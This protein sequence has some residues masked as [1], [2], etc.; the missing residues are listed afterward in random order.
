MRL[1]EDALERELAV[2]DTPARIVSLVPSLTELVYA[3]GAGGRLVGAS[4]YC[5]EP[6][7]ELDGLR[8]VGGQ[9]D[10]D[11]DA[12]VALEPDLVLAVKEENLA[13]DVESLAGRGIAVYV[14]DVCTVEQAVGLIGEIADLVDGTPRVAEQLAAAARAGVDEA[15]RLAPDPPLPV[16]CPVWR[17]P[18]I[19][20]SPQTYMFDALRTC[21]GRPVPPGRHDRRYPKVT[22][23]EVRAAAPRLVLLPDEPYA[24][25]AEDA[26]E[27]AAIAPAHHVDGKLLGWYGPRT[28]GLPALA[29]LLGDRSE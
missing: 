10:P 3:V 2:P 18:W 22:L 8:R 17:D 7:G 5:S 6:R 23:D 13:R 1:I 26:A 14:A 12:I 21:G 24:F 20:L 27:L 15:R 28:A 9:K 29:R 11:L 16:F 25:S 19:T 4:R